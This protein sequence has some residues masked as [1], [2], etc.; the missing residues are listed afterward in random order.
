MAKIY[1]NIKEKI[2][3]YFKFE[4]DSY[5]YTIGNLLFF[6]IFSYFYP[7]VFIN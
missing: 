5:V 6:L 2:K 3:W 7:L 1:I 4:I